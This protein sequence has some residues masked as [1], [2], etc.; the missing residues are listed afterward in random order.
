MSYA[1]VVSSIDRT[2]MR[3][4]T[5]V[6]AQ[7]CTGTGAKEVITNFDTLTKNCLLR[8][9]RETNQQPRKIIYFRDG[10]GDGQ[11]KEVRTLYIQII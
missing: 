6:K 2:G 1:A 8:F 10:V 4:M 11:F 5:Q 7:L 9:R 3:Y